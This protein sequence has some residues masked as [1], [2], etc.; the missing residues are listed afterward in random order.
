MTTRPLVLHLNVDTLPGAI[1]LA[2]AEGHV[3]AAYTNLV[4]AV[5]DACG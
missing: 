4:E 2:T 5:R 1:R 3:E